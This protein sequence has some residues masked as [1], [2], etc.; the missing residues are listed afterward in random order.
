[1]RGP[2][3]RL[4]YDVRRRWKCPQCGA[5]RLVP[6]TET[7][8]RCTCSGSSSQTN[9]AVQMKLI[10]PQRYVRATPPPLDLVMT[11]ADCDPEPESTPVVQAESVSIEVTEIE[12]T[13]V[14]TEIIEENEARAQES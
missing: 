7:T 2:S 11:E 4:K 5:E 13:E 10:E 14:V 1:M 3:V 12:I 9:T 8:V 6:A